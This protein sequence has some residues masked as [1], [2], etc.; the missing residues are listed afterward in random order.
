MSRTLRIRF[1]LVVLGG[2]LLGTVVGADIGAYFTFH[3][4]LLA[5][6]SGISGAMFI[7]AAWFGTSAALNKSND[8]WNTLLASSWSFAAVA[9]LPL[10][11]L[12]FLSYQSAQELD[13][14]RL[15]LF[16][17]SLVLFSLSI[18]L[19]F[20]LLAARFPVLQR[21]PI[22]AAK[23][24]PAL[25][26]CISILLWTVVASVADILK[27]FYLHELGGN[28]AMF[29]EML[30][31]TFS[32]KGVLYSQFFQANGS[33]LL[34]LH[35][36]IIWFLV[37]PIYE[38]WPH[39]QFLLSFSD[40]VLALA[41]IPIYFLSRRFFSVGVS[42]LF[43]AMYLFN[44]TVLAQ[45]GV[46]ELTEERFLPVLLIS[47][48]YFWQVKRFLPFMIFSLLSLTVR[49]DVGLILIFFGI[50]SF[51]KSRDIK[52]SLLPTAIGLGWLLSM[53]FVLIPHFNPAGVNSRPEVY[54]GSLGSSNKEII[55][56][57]LMRPWL[58]VEQAFRNIGH[59][60]TIYGVWQTFSFGLFIISG[61][62]FMAVPAFAELIMLD[63]P[64]LDHFNVIA[65]TAAIFPAMILGMFRLQKIS[66][67]RLGFS[68]VHFFL[69]ISLFATI[70]LSLTWFTPSLYSAPENYNTVMAI[71]N[72]I[73]S[74]ASV[75]L[76]QNVLIRADQNLD[77]R[78]YHQA[79]YQFTSGDNLAI[80]QNYI[81]LPHMTGPDAYPDVR[82]TIGLNA[83]KK[84][85]ETS[86]EYRRVLDRDGMEVYVRNGYP[87]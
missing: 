42:L 70:I 41:A 82:Y 75:W 23:H 24:H 78:S 46:S 60:A 15:G 2:V 33:S 17:Q 57:L 51:F 79:P 32:G 83:V 29:S 5:A 73:P 3:P 35:A 80:T 26:L 50:Y 9:I 81:V 8:F 12:P 37:Y 36:S 65:I 69:I 22:R 67:K 11:Y 44:R 28:T 72:R 48:F 10:L 68:P 6:I 34:G 14:Q 58:F 39:W 87:W 55:T 84:Q 13:T 63:H 18:G 49:E 56:N 30:N 20:S 38:I 21:G 16:W 52:W 25:T 27:T 77:M 47:A 54:Y 4:I 71:L 40:F 61:A 64:N 85:V 7:C 86:K 59:L 74:G 53:M 76:P 19:V 1:L 62:F 45:P 66:L 31:N 43:V